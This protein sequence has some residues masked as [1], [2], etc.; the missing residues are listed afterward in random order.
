MIVPAQNFDRV[1]AAV[2][3]NRPRGIYLPTAE[4]SRALANGFA[5]FDDCPPLSGAKYHRDEVL[6]LPPQGEGD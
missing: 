1:A 2:R 5:L 4:A 3:R 6:L